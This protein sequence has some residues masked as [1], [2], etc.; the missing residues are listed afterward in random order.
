M[1][2]E[3]KQ[4]L[5]KTVTDLKAEIAAIRSGRASP[6]LVENLLVETYGGQTKLKLMELA[7]ISTQGVS[8]L[9]IFPF[10]PA[11]I[12]DIEKAILA[13]P[14]GLTPRVEGKAIHLNIPPLSEEQ[15]KRLTKIISQKVEAARERVRSIRDQA[16]K[17]IKL[18]LA[19]KEISEDQKFRLEKEIDK[20]TQEINQK[21]EQ[22]KEKK[23]KEVMEI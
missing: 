15:R 1:L 23:E 4:N 13:S 19:N 9:L 11:I 16:R 22:I 20:I 10:D 14:L 18:A 7:T 21:I 5:E 2:S 17:K 3:F 6:S 12:S 8:S